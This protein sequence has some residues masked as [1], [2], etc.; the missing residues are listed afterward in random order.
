MFINLIQMM[1][2]KDFV[3]HPKHDDNQIFTQQ[4]KKFEVISPERG[5]N[6]KYNKFFFNG[7]NGRGRTEIL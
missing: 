7:N 2:Q 1:M 5:A 3:F 4:H 6:I